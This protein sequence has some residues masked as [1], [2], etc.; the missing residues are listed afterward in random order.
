VQPSDAYLQVAAFLL[1]DLWQR[2]G[3]EKH[4]W[5]AVVQLE[6]GARRSPANF[7]FKLLLMRLYSEMGE[8]CFFSQHNLMQFEAN[9][10]NCVEKVSL[11]KL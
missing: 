9:S 2:S 8:C 6:L 7:Q 3:Q 5:Q 1:V 10:C 4:L 11:W